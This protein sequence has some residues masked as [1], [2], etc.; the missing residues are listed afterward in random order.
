VT[1]LSRSAA[2]GSVFSHSC[3]AYDLHP[4]ILNKIWAVDPTPMF[5]VLYTLNLLRWEFFCPFLKN[6]IKYLNRGKIKF[7]WSSF[8]N[9][10]LF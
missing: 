9:K 6:M 3:L 4:R 10:K 2:M 5:F 7:C 8:F 1:S